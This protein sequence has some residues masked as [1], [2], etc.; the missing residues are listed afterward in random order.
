VFKQYLD[1]YINN[2]R[3]F[4]GGIT[5]GRDLI[6]IYIYIGHTQK[7]GEVSNVIRKFISHPRRG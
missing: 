5:D 2:I 1:Y 3:G 4:C 6:Y 7:K